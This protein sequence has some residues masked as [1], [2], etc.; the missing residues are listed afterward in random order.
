MF[1][2]ELELPGHAFTDLEPSLTDVGHQSFGQL[3]VAGR[4]G[5]CGS[6]STSC[7]E[8]FFVIAFDGA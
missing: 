6:R 7:H 4:A 1:F 3:T 8:R 5:R 2:L